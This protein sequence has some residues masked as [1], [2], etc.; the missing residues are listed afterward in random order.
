[1][2]IYAF[3]IDGTICTN[4]YG[5]Y[6]LAQPYKNR[7]E[8]INRLYYEGHTIKM[9]TARGSTTKKDWYEFTTNQITSWGLKFHE[10]ITG[11]PEADLFIDD[12]AINHN[13]WDWEKGF[14]GKYDADTDKVKKYLTKFAESIELIEQ[15]RLLI[16]QITSLGKKLESILSNGGKIIFAGNGGSFADSQHLAAELISKLNIDRVPLPG[17]AL[18]TNSSSTTAI[19]NDYGFEY[20]FS[21]ELE[22]I[23]KDNDFLIAISTSGESKNIIN[24]LEKSKSLGISNILLTGPNKNSNAAKIAESVINTPPTCIATAEIQQIHITIGHILCD[25]AQQQF[26]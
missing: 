12:K 20:I 16:S 15:D 8:S 22:A 13:D 14:N 3:D 25:F 9:F 4:T 26:I 17:I 10:L 7:I 6:E 5:N 2:K 23:G 18:G 19:G 21:R 1:M 24:L 11:K